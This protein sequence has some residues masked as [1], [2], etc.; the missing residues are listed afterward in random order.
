[1]KHVLRAVI[2]LYSW[3]AQISLPPQAATTVNITYC[4]LSMS[5]LRGGC[6]FIMW[7]GHV[8]KGVTGFTPINTIHPVVVPAITDYIWLTFWSVETSIQEFKKKTY[9]WNR[10]VCIASKIHFKFLSYR[11][12]VPVRCRSQLTGLFSVCRSIAVQHQLLI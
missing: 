2:Q 10:S 6:F 1:M 9:A 5:Y 8:M 11:Q 3:L 4:L 12:P 7:R